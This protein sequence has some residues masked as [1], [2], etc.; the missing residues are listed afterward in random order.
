[1][2]RIK[3]ARETA[4]QRAM[5]APRPVL[6]VATTFLHDLAAIEPFDRAMTLAAQAFTSIFPLLITAATFV[7]GGDGSMG[8]N[9][10]NKLSL[11]ESVTSALEQALPTDSPQFAAFGIVSLLI[12]LVSATSFS[13]ALGRMYARAWRVPPSGWSGGWRWI[14]VILAVCVSTL[15]TRWLNQAAGALAENVAALWVTFLVNA[16]LFTWVPWLLLVGRV[17]VIRLVPSGVL[18]GVASIGLYLASLV[19]MP[20]A[21]QAG[22]EHFGSFGVAF[23]FI[24]WLFV[25][26]FVLIAATV[27]GAVIVQDKGVESLVLDV[28]RRLSALFHSISPG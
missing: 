20:H 24:G 4:V 22:T 28:R 18:M 17:S 5:Q 14:A 2:A 3:A 13:R 27:F 11:S 23:T 1:M 10:S 19:Y 15:V 26:S 8:R 12:V 9:I 16:V 6:R 21:L 7:D 25:A